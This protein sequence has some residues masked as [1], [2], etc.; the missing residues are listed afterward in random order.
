MNAELRPTCIKIGGRAATDE[1]AFDSL[2]R[3]MAARAASTQLIV[4]HGGGAEVTR[5]SERLGI[6]PVFEN[7]VRMTSPSEME[8]VDMVLAGKM[9]KQVVRR[10]L[11][12]GVPAVGLSG[13]D[14]GLV[15]GTPIGGETRTGRVVRVDP[16]ILLLLGRDGYV[17]VIASTASTADGIALNINADEIALALATQIHAVVLLFL[18][19]TPGILDREGKTLESL[20]ELQAEAQIA[21][22]VISGG[23]IPKVRSAVQALKAGVGAIVIG[24]YEKNGDLEKLLD[25]RLGTHVVSTQRS[26][27]R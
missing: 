2:V 19:D 7:G 20:D 10:F 1:G 23:M 14:G 21:S 6:S 12:H 26:R 9:N 18:S 11:A 3:E 27:T 16:R 15:T 8:I 25:G 22:G 17:P 24:R 13:S 4:V 5:L